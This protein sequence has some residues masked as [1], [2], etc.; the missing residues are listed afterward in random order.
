[1]T[2]PAEQGLAYFSV[3][4]PRLLL[5][6][7]TFSLVVDGDA[8]EREIAVHPHFPRCVSRSRICMIY[9]YVVEA[10]QAGTSVA[11]RMTL[12]KCWFGIRHYFHA[13]SKR[14]RILLRSAEGARTLSSAPS[15]RVPLNS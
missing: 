14:R 9:V 3:T 11:V 6:L 15:A 2:T 7:R 1:M 5:Q 4:I 12:G 13:R 8:C 10:V